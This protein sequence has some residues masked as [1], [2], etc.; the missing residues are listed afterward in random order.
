MLY[1]FTPFVA[2]H[3]YLDTTSL[4]ELL[5]TLGVAGIKGGQGGMV[6][7]K[8]WHN[9]GLNHGSVVKRVWCSTVVLDQQGASV[10]FTAGIKGT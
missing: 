5:V 7:G 4:L 10:H 2:S 1:V 8:R 9:S 6:D 3:I